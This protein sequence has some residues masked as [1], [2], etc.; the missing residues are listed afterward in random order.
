MGQIR[1]G[2]MK[3]GWERRVWPRSQRAIPPADMLARLYYSENAVAD[4]TSSQPEMFTNRNQCP[5]CERRS[6]VGYD[7]QLEEA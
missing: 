2:A 4:S 1:K 7:S 6:T 3:D 5:P